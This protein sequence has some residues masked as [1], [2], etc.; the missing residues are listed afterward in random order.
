MLGLKRIT[1]GTGAPI[2]KNEC[3]RSI[4]DS[5]KIASL[6]SRRQ[7]GSVTEKVIPHGNFMLYIITKWLSL[8]LDKQYSGQF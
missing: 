7:T 6:L 2:I 5:Y 8:N 4:M 3:R 1:T